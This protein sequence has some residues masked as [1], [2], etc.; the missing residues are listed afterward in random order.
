MQP[1]GG[2]I[3]PITSTLIFDNEP[4]VMADGRIAFIRSD[5]FFDRAK[6]ETQIHVIRPDGT[7]GH[8]EI[9]AEVGADYGI[10]LRALGYGSP[11][12]LPDGRLACISNR[13]NFLCIPG[14]A[15]ETFHRLPDGLGDLAPLPDG[16]LLATVLRPSGN[17]KES[18]VLAVIDPRDNRVV[19]IYQSAEGSVHSPVFVGPRARPPVLAETIDPRRV[20][21]PG[22]TG[23]LNCQNVRFTRKHKADWQQVR[24]NPRARRHPVDHAVIAFTHRPCRP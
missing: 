3:R 5:N 6:V 12:P 15:E 9:G 10:R 2:E 19:P 24:A 13:G 21:M 16:R 4:K 23:F 22:T 7:D 11:A 1:D 18:D 8:T 17:R 14:S 20:G